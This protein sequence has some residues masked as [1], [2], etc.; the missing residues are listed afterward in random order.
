MVRETQPASDAGAPRQTEAAES[1]R[2]HDIL[3][4]LPMTGVRAATFAGANG[5]VCLGPRRPF[6]GS[7]A[8]AG[9]GVRRLRTRG[10]FET[11]KQGFSLSTGSRRTSDSRSRSGLSGPVKA[12]IRTDRHAWHPKT[13][14]WPITC[15]IPLSHLRHLRGDKIDD[16]DA[17]RG[18]DLVQRFQG[19]IGCG[20]FECADEGLTHPRCVGEIVLRP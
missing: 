12:R 17:E 11:E 13:A 7:P 14:P 9:R 18:R 20:D 5:F 19:G 1:V 4:G 6:P 10:L 3:P 15:A 16:L 8:K 2:P